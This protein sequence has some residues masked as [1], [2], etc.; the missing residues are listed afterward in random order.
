M[1]ITTTKELPPRAEQDFYPTPS[2]VAAKACGLVRGYPE[3]ILD[4]GAGNGVFGI[5]ARR[6]WP[7]ARIVGVEIQERFQKP[8]E[9]TEW[10]TE[11]FA[12]TNLICHYDLIL[13]NP[14][15]KHAEW[16][17]RKCLGA[18]S[19]GGVA[20]FL[21]RLAFLEGQARARGLWAE[22]N[23]ERVVILSKRPSFDGTG[24]TNATAFALYQWRAGWEGETRISWI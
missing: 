16:W 21:L 23:P 15:Y 11:D 22:M 8:E 14:P 4:P 3:S 10:L 13:G 9:Y 20:I 2:W 12:D 7:E 19:F 5:E 18:L 17:V 1:I 6:Q 24:R